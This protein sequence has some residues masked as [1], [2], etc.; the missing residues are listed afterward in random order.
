MPGDRRCIDSGRPLSIRPGSGLS[1]HGQLGVSIQLAGDVSIRSA[2]L[3]VDTGRAR[4][5]GRRPGRRSPR[6]AGTS[7]RSTVQ[8]EGLTPRRPSSRLACRLGAARNGAGWRQGCDSQV[9]TCSARACVRSNAAVRTRAHQASAWYRESC[10][11]VWR[12]PSRAAWST[13]EPPCSG[14]SRCRRPGRQPALRFFV[15]RVL[16]RESRS[17]G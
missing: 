7:A 2:R 15:G 16:T 6:N 11:C 5:P 9:R 17:L 3:I 8:I 12:L 13:A 1:I 10:P 4:R 14:H